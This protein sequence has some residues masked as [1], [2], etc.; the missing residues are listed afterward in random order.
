MVNDMIFHD[1]E[2]DDEL[3]EKLFLL[4][5]TP[6]RD[7]EKATQAREAFMN[8][9]KELR[10]IGAPFLASNRSKG[11]F[12]QM[13]FGKRPAFAPLAL[14]LVIAVGLIFGGGW[15]TVYAAQGS[16]PNDFLYPVKLAA[17]NLHLALTADPEAK[18]ELLTT[19]TERR[20]DEAARLSA[21]GE[22]IPAEL[23]TLVEEQ[24]D[25]I[26]TL[27][28]S[29]NADEMEA[30]LLAVQR[31]LRPQDRIQGMTNTM[32]GQPLPEGVD[33]QLLRLQAMLQECQEL[34]THGLGEPNTFQHQFRYQQGQPTL[35]ITPT[36]TTTITSTITSTVTITPEVT[37]TLTITPGH[38]GPGPCEVPGACTPPAEDHGP[39]QHKGTPPGPDDPEGYGPG[40][41][42]GV[43]PQY[44]TATPTPDGEEPVATPTPSSTKS[45]SKGNLGNKGK[46]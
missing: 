31:T 9:V 46:P 30:S 23:P 20:L 29:M 21:R 22:P 10:S 33:P 45:K 2:L 32:G 18:V 5:S 39:F 34:A 41:E 43:G 12:L 37:V 40:Y 8:K 11:G 27:A 44:P 24:L 6:N 13:L 4:T 26:F 19:Y 16:L 14:A 28:A 1:D 7:A 35:P 42:Q 36:L 38:Y 17:E 25:E 15:G 3:K